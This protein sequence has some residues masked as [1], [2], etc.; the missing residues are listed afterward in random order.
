MTE[1]SSAMITKTSS[2]I[3][4]RYNEKTIPFEQESLERNVISNVFDLICMLKFKLRNDIDM[5]KDIFLRHKENEYLNSETLISDLFNTENTALEMV[6][7]DDFMDKMSKLTINEYESELQYASAA[8]GCDFKN[9]LKYVEYFQNYI[10]K[11]YNNSKDTYIPYV[12]IIQS[13]G[14]GKSRL[15]KEH[16]NQ[17]YTLYLNLG[18]DQNCFPYTSACAKEFIRS[19]QIAKDPDTWFNTFLAKAVSLV[20]FEAKDNNINKNLFWKNHL[21]DNGQSIWKSAIKVANDTKISD[22]LISIRDNPGYLEENFDNENEIKILLCID[23]G[24]KLIQ[25]IND[26]LNISLFQCWKHALQKNKWRTKGLFSVILDTTLQLTNFSPALEYNTTIKTFQEDR[27]LFKPFIYI[28]TYDSLANNSGKFYSQAFSIG[29]PCWK[30]FRDEFIKEVNYNDIKAEDYAWEKVKLLAKIKLQGGT[31]N[32]FINN[33]KN[34]FTSIAIF[35][36]FCSI[37]ISSSVHFASNLIANHLGTFL[38]ISQDRTK[39]LVCYPSEPLV[40]EAAYE[41]L[42]NNILQLIA[43]SFSQGIVNLGKQDEI[44]GELILILTHQKLYKKLIKT[45]QSAFFT[46][47]IRLVTFLDNLLKNNFTLNENCTEHNSL[48]NG[49]ISFTRFVTIRTIPTLNDIKKGY[50]SCVAF[51]LK[52]NQQGAN[53]LIPVKLNKNIY[54]VWII[55]IKNHNLDKYNSDIMVD[56]ISKLKPRYV[57]SKT[58]LAELNPY[59]SMYWQLGAHQTSIETVEWKIS[60]KT[61]HSKEKKL[62]LTHY[63]ISSLKSFKVAYGD[64]LKNLR[65]I[66]EAYIDPYDIFWTSDRFLD[67]PTNYI[68]SFLPWHPPNNKINSEVLLDKYNDN[69]D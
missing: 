34:T 45:K 30:A 38:S 25:E 33:E 68:E 10:I 48:K 60:S 3:W 66:L 35:A 52:Q 42:D 16:A 43:Q 11:C 27:M 6:I 59:L 19:F 51:N 20:V 58:D 62:P 23:E 63:T 17:V 4:I 1:T 21:D 49:S 57:F 64:T 8:F 65:S 9:T 50:I 18:I 56:S 37:D 54:T 46:G 47:E 15:I 61:Q 26:K 22:D 31:N 7:V 53:F 28:P 24:R 44:V 2:I 13:S 69:D 55:Q 40:T 39:I 5:K 32:S 36:S 67:D 29:R 41:L 12:P 14:Y